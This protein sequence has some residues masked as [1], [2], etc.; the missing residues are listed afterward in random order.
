MKKKICLTFFLIL[1][2]LFLN[3]YADT[4]KPQDKYGRDDPFEPIFQGVVKTNPKSLIL[5]GIVSHGDGLHAVING[6]VV[7]VGDKVG[8]GN[9]VIDIKDDYVILNNGTEYFEL[10]LGETR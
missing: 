9:V 3:G 7:N 1:L 10:K 2:C 6:V 4:E 8:L 5:E